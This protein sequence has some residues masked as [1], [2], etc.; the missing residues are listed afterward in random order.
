MDFVAA[1]PP[2]YAEPHDIVL[3]PDGSHLY[4]AGNGND[5]VVNFTEYLDIIRTV[6]GSAYGSDGPRYL[7][8]DAAGRLY[9]AD[10]YNHRVQ[11]LSPDGEL[12]LTVG[13]GGA[14]IG[15]D[16]FDRPEGVAIRGRDVWFSDT[17]NDRIVRYRVRDDSTKER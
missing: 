15:P 11:V 16:L 10:K 1:P 5:R 13:K 14:G 6:G 12:L 3:A 7:D 4:V 8:M 9:I 2:F 17:H